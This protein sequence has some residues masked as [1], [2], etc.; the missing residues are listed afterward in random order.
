MGA[1]GDM[2]GGGDFSAEQAGTALE[3]GGDVAVQTAAIVGD[4]QFQLLGIDRESAG[5]V[6]GAGVTDDVGEALFVSVDLGAVDPTF[7]RMDEY[8]PQ[9]KSDRHRVYTR[10]ALV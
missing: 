9:K 1:T 10:C 6:G 7:R 3:R 8:P 5:D 2:R 4:A